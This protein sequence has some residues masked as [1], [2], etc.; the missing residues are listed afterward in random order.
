MAAVH[1]LIRRLLRCASAVLVE[2][3]RIE[4]RGDLPDQTPVPLEGVPDPMEMRL[5]GPGGG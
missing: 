4:K 3:N 1:Y 5:T 2:V